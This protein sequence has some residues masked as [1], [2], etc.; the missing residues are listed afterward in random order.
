M[1]TGIVKGTNSGCLTLLASCLILKE[2]DSRQKTDGSISNAPFRMPQQPYDNW[3]TI[4]LSV[5]ETHQ[6]ENNNNTY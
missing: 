4:E 3:N 2:R 6:K 1:L 5:K